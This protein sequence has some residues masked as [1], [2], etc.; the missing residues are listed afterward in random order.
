MA[1]PR[2]LRSRAIADLVDEHRATDNHTGIVEG[3]WAIGTFGVIETTADVTAVRQ[4]IQ[5]SLDSS[6]Q[7]GPRDS[8]AEIDWDTKRE[9]REAIQKVPDECMPT[10]HEVSGRCLLE[11]AHR[12]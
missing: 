2:G 4:L 7:L 3:E 1:D 6:C 10:R 12:I 5:F 9:G 11:P 8:K